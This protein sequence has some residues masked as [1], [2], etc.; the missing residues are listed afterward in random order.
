M[1]KQTKAYLLTLIAVT[2]WGTAASAF[3]I[4]LQYVTPYLLLFYAAL[5]STIALFIIIIL[6]GK[7]SQLFN[8]TL[9]QI[10]KAALLGFL[11]PFLYYTVLFKAYSLLPGQIAMAL[12]YGWPLALALLSVPILKQTLSRAQLIAVVISFCGAIIIATKGQFAGFNEVS[13]LGLVLAFGSTIIWALFW[14]FNARDG[15]DPVTKLFSGFCFGLIYS[16]LFSPLFDGLHLPDVRALLPL[17]YI[18]LFEMGITFV[19]WLT[20]LELSS[21]AARVGNLIYI[22]PFLSLIFL[23]IIIGEEIHFATFLGLLLIV[24]SI[25]FQEMAAKKVNTL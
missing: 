18:G 7:V 16:V 20:A 1:Q 11:N 13:K 15:L 22:S 9:T 21:T 10:G 12:N 2:F 14:L 4:A 6:Q 19:L 23:R 3:K 5:V 24:G 17:L 25:L 8:I